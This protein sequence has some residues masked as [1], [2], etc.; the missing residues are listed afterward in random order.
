M[1]YKLLIKSISTILMLGILCILILLGL[2]SIVIIPLFPLLTILIVIAFVSY[3]FFLEKNA[4]G[5]AK[6]VKIIYNI[7]DYANIVISAVFIVQIIFFVW[8]FPA[9]VLQAS[10]NPTLYENEKVIISHNNSKLNRFDII[11]FKVDQ[12]KQVNISKIEDQELWVK[13]IIG[14][15]GETINYLDGKLYV[16]DELVIEHYLYDENNHFFSG[17][18]TDKKGRLSSYNTYTQ[19]F[20]LTSI[21]NLSHFSGET[22][23]E[24][25]F[26]L[27][28]DNRGY[29]KDSR[30]IGLVHRSQIIGK[31]KY[32]IRSLFVWEKL[33]D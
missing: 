4:F 7:I 33:G 19:D 1:D 30:Y 15:P 27:L 25:Y 22:I 17:V 10:M 2:N 23:P 18:Y 8:F 14:L 29:S 31:G 11:V 13:R 6:K 32:I 16:N 21:L 12:K 28:G 20:A 3:R 24:D 9:T 5:N 26:L